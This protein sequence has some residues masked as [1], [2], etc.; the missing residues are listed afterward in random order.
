MIEKYKITDKVGSKPWTLGIMY[1]IGSNRKYI[2]A[3][4]T[5]KKHPVK[6]QD[7]GTV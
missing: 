4:I 2:D 6:Q 3:I 5:H 7:T 1:T